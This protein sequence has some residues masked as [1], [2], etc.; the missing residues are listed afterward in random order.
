MVSAETLVALG[1]VTVVGVG[2]VG[3]GY[4]IAGELLSWIGWIGGAVGGAG[5]GW[6]AGPKL[7]AGGPEIRAAVAVGGVIAG[8]ILGRIVVPAASRLAVVIAG[9]L[10]AA[11]ATLVVLVGGRVTNALAA[12]DL[13][14]PSTAV[15]VLDRVGASVGT[16][17]ETIVTVAVVGLLGAIVAA[18]FYTVLLTALTTGVGAILLGIVGPLWEQALVGSVSLGGG[19]GALSP[20]WALLAFVA[21]VAFQYYRHGDAADL[22][23]PA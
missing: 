11:G 22:P 5:V 20:T 17:E 23:T 2:C 16:I 1:V 10:A 19:F 7:L 12:V 13:A 9:F 3:F 8:A 18:R 4:D 15:P 14:E 6:L 21:G